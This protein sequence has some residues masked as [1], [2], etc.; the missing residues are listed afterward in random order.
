MYIYIN[1]KNILISD[2]NVLQLL[3]DELSKYFKLDELHK[4]DNII[5]QIEGET[6]NLLI[7]AKIIYKT[8]ELIN[9]I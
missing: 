2:E 4:D 3:W 7:D 8:G 9:K 1:H 6:L 5:L